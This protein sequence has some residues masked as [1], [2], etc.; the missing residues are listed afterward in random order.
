[1]QESM[2]DEGLPKEL[3]GPGD[4]TQSPREETQIRSAASANDDSIKFLLAEFAHIGE[5]WRQAD[6][7]I[8]SNLRLYLAATTILVTGIAIL[9]QQ[10]KVFRVF[11]L[12]GVAVAACLFVGGLVLARNVLTTGFLKANYIFA[13]NLIRRYFVDH[14]KSLDEYLFFPSDVSKAT[15]SQKV[16]RVPVPRTLFAGIAAWEGVLLGG[17]FAG[18]TWL[19]NPRLFPE[20][21]VGGGIVLAVGC[22][23]ELTFWARQRIRGWQKAGPAA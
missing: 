21:S 4:A 15:W 6:S 18:V 14:D 16:K 12:F 19:V 17:I 3:A 22:F 5:F 1:M 20:V 13:L 10:V 7:R 23:A 11:A 9:S 2:S 8:E